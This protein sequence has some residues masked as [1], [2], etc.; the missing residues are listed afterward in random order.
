MVAIEVMNDAKWQAT[1][2]VSS[3][4]GDRGN[5]SKCRPKV[6][7]DIISK[8]PSKTLQGLSIGL[9]KIISF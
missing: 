5:G 6:D 4:D 3:G 7:E 8:Y 2:R 9:N 1:M